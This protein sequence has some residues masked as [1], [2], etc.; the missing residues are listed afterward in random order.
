MN[1]LDDFPHVWNPGKAYQNLFLPELRNALRRWSFLRHSMHVLFSLNFCLKSI[2]HHW[3]LVWCF[4][5]VCVC[6]WLR[7]SPRN[8]VV[9]FYLTKW[10]IW[11]CQL[12]HY[13]QSKKDA[14]WSQKQVKGFLAKIRNYCKILLYTCGNRAYAKSGPY[15]KKWN[16]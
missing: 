11:K 1:F 14:C 12:T 10:I 6:F 4:V 13:Y 9:L 7:F 5:Y 16:Y 3:C 15:I 2:W 8:F